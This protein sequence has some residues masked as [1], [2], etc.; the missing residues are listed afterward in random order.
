[1]DDQVR[2]TCPDLICVVETETGSPIT[3]PNCTQGMDVT[4][5]GFPCHEIWKSQRG[6]DILNPRFFGFDS[7]CV[8]L[9][10]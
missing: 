10:D 8:F 9:E 2:L 3:N 5:L 7:D 6:L 1:M 4:V